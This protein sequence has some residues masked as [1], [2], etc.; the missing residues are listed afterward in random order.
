M[1]EGG[2]IFFVWDVKLPGT[3]QD[4]LL[5]QGGASTWLPLVQIRQLVFTG[6]EREGFRPA[7][8]TLTTGERTQGDLAV[9]GLLEGRTDLGS[10]TIPLKEVRHLTLEQP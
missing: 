5:K 6:P 4:I 10:W 3:S 9:N 7:T 8:I 1:S 2:T